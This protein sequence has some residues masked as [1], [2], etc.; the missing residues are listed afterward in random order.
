[1]KNTFFLLLSIFVI[2]IAGCNKDEPVACT[3]ETNPE[4]PNYDPCHDAESTS[5][6]FET[7][8][9][10]VSDKYQKITSQEDTF[11]LGA[12][13]QFTAKQEDAI[14]YEWKIGDDDR[15]FTEQSF[16]LTFNPSD[17]VTLFNRAVPIQLIVIRTPNT[18]CFPTDDGIDTLTKYIYFVSIHEI[19]HKKFLGTWVGSR[20]DK[21]DDIYE[22][23]IS[24]E[25]EID[26]PSGIPSFYELQFKNFDNEGDGSCLFQQSTG[27]VS[28]NNFY[29]GDF[30]SSNVL[31]C[32]RVNL[33][34]PSSVYGNIDEAGNLR[35][36]WSR[37]LPPDYSGVVKRVF[38]GRRK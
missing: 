36:E 24:D 1:M 16:S 32:Q 30:F 8:C 10:V 28:Y 22:I 4:C 18:D 33:T 5:A 31:E 12:N 11:Y 21:P 14:S 38:N 20:E 25:P 6:D 15:V 23:E 27:R 2:L 26:G 3:D 9:I 35:I 17:S 37:S 13:I 29:I 19:T 34:S 7:A